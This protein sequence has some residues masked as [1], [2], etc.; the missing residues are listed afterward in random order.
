MAG[1]YI[2]TARR[3][4]SRASKWVWLE[5]SIRTALGAAGS[6]AIARLLTL[7][8]AFW[9]SVT[10]LIVMQS[11]LGAAWTVSKQRLVGTALGAVAGALV[12]T[13]AAPG[14]VVYGLGV[15]ALGLLCG[16]L[17]LDQTAYRFAGITLTIVLLVVRS[18]GPWLI[19]A[20]RFVEVSLGIAVGLGFAAFWPPR[21]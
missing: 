12:A 11:T 10:T 9:A 5:R 2:D 7:P 8:E 13:W 1:S 19:A 4:F 17:R 14:V 18:Q 15:L 3:L 6:F 16:L 20:H 21:E